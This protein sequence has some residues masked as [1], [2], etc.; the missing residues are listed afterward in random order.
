MAMRSAGLA[1]WDQDFVTGR[2]QRSPAWSEML[3]FAPDEVGSS[4]VDWRALVH[5]DDLAVVEE[6]ASLHESGAT[7]VFE[8][9]HRMRTRDGGWR[10]ILNWGRIVERDSG[11]RP[12]RALGTHLDI[13]R[14]K[15]AEL[16]RDRLVQ[17]LEASLAAVQSLPSL[18]PICAS[19]KKIRDECGTWT[20][21][22]AYIVAHSQASFSHGLCPGCAER[23]YPGGG[24]I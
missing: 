12:L 24:W 22:E 5:P 18:I 21:I 4:L 19:C 1:W 7:P 15:Q 13:T 9:E 11:G 14:R 20:P 10:W 6:R 3:G 17:A 2:V 23:L 16:D 8:V